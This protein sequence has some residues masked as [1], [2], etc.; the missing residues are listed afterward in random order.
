MTSWSYSSISMFKQC[1]KKYFEIRVAKSVKDEDNEA[2]SYGHEV[3]GA[4]EHYFKNDEPIPE[5][6]GYMKP[7][8]EAAAQL[9]GT[10]FVEFKMGVKKTSDGFA[11]CDFFAGDVWWR[12]ISDLTVVA[13]RK[14]YIIDWKAGK[15]TRYAD[16]KQLDLL[17][18]ATFV[19]FPQVETVEAVLVFVACGELVP[20]QPKVY[21]RELMGSYLSV[22][23][24][25]LERLENAM[26]TGNF[27]PVQSG[28]C[29]RHCAVLDCIYNGRH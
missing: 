10:K 16:L 29:F 22:F 4:A 7:I 8:V 19:H 24:A 17:A 27:P 23:D 9:P 15:S 26:E 13:K 2:S 20:E 6:F 28:L 21:Q 18:G 1:P 14:A 11:P 25:E 12:G 3:H 5:K